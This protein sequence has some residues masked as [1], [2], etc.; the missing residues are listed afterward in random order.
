MGSGPVE[1]SLAV[2][3]VRFPVP[4]NPSTSPAIFRE[5]P[6]AV[7]RPS[8]RSA[9][10][11]HLR[12]LLPAAEVP[13]AAGRWAARTHTRGAH[14]WFWAPLK[15]HTVKLTKPTQTRAEIIAALPPVVASNDTYDDNDHDN[16]DGMSPDEMFDAFA[17]I[18]QPETRRALYALGGNIARA[19]ELDAMTTTANA[20]KGESDT[21]TA[22]APTTKT[23]VSKIATAIGVLVDHPDWTNKA[24]AEAAGCSPEYLSRSTIYLAARDAIRASG[25]SGTRRAAQHRGTDMDAYE[26]E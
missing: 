19:A 2:G 13:L 1:I 6:T 22:N 23:N 21:T 17:L 11:R 18:L 10:P 24:I 8:A 4:V 16:P 5:L 7:E 9:D 20:A 15:G 14:H 26:D 25:A 3:W 12:P